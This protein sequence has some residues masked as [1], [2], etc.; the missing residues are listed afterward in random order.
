M[1]KDQRGDRSASAVSEGVGEKRKIKGRGMSTSSPRMI[2]TDRKNEARVV[3]K[4]A[5]DYMLMQRF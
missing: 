2:D 4:L 1:F 3:N 5:A